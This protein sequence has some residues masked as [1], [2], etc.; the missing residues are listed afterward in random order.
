[1]DTEAMTEAEAI[2]FAEIYK[3]ERERG[4]I[5][6][7]AANTAAYAVFRFRREAQQ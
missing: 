1:M 4:A 6:T 3:Y 7:D 2:V 5:A